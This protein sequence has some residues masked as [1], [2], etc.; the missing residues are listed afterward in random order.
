MLISLRGWLI[1]KSFFLTSMMKLLSIAAIAD[2]V[3]VI[4]MSELMDMA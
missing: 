1:L 3:A 2:L 4:Q